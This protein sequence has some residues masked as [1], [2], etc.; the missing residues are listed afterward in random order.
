[1]QSGDCRASHDSAAGQRSSPDR[2]SPVAWLSFHASF[3][4]LQRPSISPNHQYFGV[5]QRIRRF[6]R[7][8]FT[9][10]IAWHLLTGI[11]LAGLL[12]C[13]EEMPDVLG[14][15]HAHA[16]DH[17]NTAWHGGSG[18]HGAGGDD[19]KTSPDFH[20]HVSIDHSSFD[21][22]L[23]L[24]PSV[25]AG[26]NSLWDMSGRDCLLP[27]APWMESEGPPLI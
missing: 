26:K 9:C 1:M 24:M 27:E 10:G 6:G 5:L 17:A 16:P 7:T 21:S 20:Y 4:A 23:C 2:Y 22:D 3:R 8:H 14:H 15:S 25:P 19:M 13:T 18:G 11:I 12:V